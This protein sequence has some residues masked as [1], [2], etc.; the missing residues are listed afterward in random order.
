VFPMNL[1]FISSPVLSCDFVYSLQ[2]PMS[3]IS[4]LVYL[5]SIS[6]IHDGNV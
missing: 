1:R 3:S 2:C 6:I 4:G 5:M